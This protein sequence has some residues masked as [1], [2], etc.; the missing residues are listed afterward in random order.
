MQ[1]IPFLQYTSMRFLYTA[2]AHGH[3][4]VKGHIFLL[5]H[6]GKV[7]KCI[8]CMSFT[9]NTPCNENNTV[10]K[11]MYVLMLVD[12]SNAVSLKSALIY[13]LQIRHLTLQI[14]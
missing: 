9:Q 2:L 4:T 7:T 10:I 11:L 6:E 14:L 3:M 13:M 1:T 8:S 12:S 5:W